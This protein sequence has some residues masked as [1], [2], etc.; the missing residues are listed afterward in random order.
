MHACVDGHLGCFRSLHF[1]LLASSPF[2]SPSLTISIFIVTD[3]AVSFGSDWMTS[4][5]LTQKWNVC[6]QLS[7]ESYFI[8][9]TGRTNSQSLHK[10]ETSEGLFV[11]TPKGN[12]TSKVLILESGGCSEGFLPCSP[13]PV[14]TSS[15]SHDGGGGGRHSLSCLDGNVPVHPPSCG[16][17]LYLC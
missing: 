12:R 11:S 7:W 1:P 15:S 3:A 4:E 6:H 16:I 14:K 9:H 10:S 13:D 8:P 17:R 2:L 5:I